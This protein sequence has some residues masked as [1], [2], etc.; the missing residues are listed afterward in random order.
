MNYIVRFVRRDNK[1]DEEYYY[2]DVSDATYH[3]NLFLEDDSALY[4]RIELIGLTPEERLI[5]V[6][7]YA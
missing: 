1:P 4:E 5:K 7:V 3:F 2:Q 6:N